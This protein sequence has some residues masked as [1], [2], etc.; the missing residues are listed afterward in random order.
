M[1]RIT[2]QYSRPDVDS[3]WLCVPLSRHRE[4]EFSLG[5]YHSKFCLAGVYLRSFSPLLYK[6]R[7]CF[8]IMRFLGNPLLRRCKTT[9]DVLLMFVPCLPARKRLIYQC[10][11]FT[12]IVLKTHRDEYLIFIL[13]LTQQLLLPLVHVH[14]GLGDSLV[15]ASADQNFRENELVQTRDGNQLFGHFGGIRLQ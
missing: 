6:L 14:N 8:P 2:H 5:L 9:I 3:Q 1:L 10:R 4:L 11:L 12:F 13:A 7:T 15:F